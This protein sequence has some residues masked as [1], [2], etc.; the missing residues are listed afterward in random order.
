MPIAISANTTYM[1]S[2]HTDTGHYAFDAGY[3]AS[4][5]IDNAPLHALRDGVD[6][7]NGA[8]HYGASSFPDQTYQAANY[9]VDVV[10]RTVVGADITPPR[11]TSVTPPDG[12]TGILTTRVLGVSFS[13]TMTT[14][15]SRTTIE[16][17]DPSKNLVPGTTVGRR[18]GSVS[19]RRRS[20]SPCSDLHCHSEGGPPA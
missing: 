4:A 19:R 8:Y 12:A 1:V 17:R 2:Y 14:S 5:G 20:R 16:L 18:A 10:F 3:F 6:G 7:P 11:V 15:R 13:E 9:W